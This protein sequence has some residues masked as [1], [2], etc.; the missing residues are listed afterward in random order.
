MSQADRRITCKG[1]GGGL[2]EDADGKL[3]QP[4]PHCGNTQRLV[5]VFDSDEISSSERAV[6]H[7]PPV[8]P[9]DPSESI[10][11]AG[12]GNRSASAD[13]SSESVSYDISGD[14]PRNEE[15]ALE[16]AQILIHKLRECDAGWTDPTMVDAADV[17]CESRNG[18]DTLSMQV[19]RVPHSSQFWRDLGQRS[20]ASRI[21]SAA[22]LA[23]ELMS[24]ITYKANRLSRTQRTGLALVLDA[25]DTPA[26]P[27]TNPAAKFSD[28]HGIEAAALGFQSIW[29]VGPTMHLVRQLA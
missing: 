1:C 12:H 5:H 2:D 24:A 28:R 13:V 8:N 25:R 10:R 4:C 20:S 15:G 11:I 27:T 23:D 29:V 17:N 9:S 3:C 16:T 26:F 6:A 22:D 21:G 18:E 19:T 7:Q 14:A